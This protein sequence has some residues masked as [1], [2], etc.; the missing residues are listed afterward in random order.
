MTAM[1]DQTPGRERNAAQPLGLRDGDDTD[2]KLSRT[3]EQEKTSAG[4]DGPDATEIG[5]TFKK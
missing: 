5:E 4:P 3:G 1:T 2:K